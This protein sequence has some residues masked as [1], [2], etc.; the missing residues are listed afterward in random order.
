MLSHKKNTSSRRRSS[1]RRKSSCLALKVNDLRAI[2]MSASQ[3]SIPASD[4]VD[5]NGTLKTTQ[6][7]CKEGAKIEK[8]TGPLL[9]ILNFLV[10][11]L[12]RAKV[13]SMKTF[14]FG[15]LMI[16]VLARIPKFLENSRVFLFQNTT[17]YRRTDNL[18]DYGLSDDLQEGIYNVKERILDLLR[19]SS[20]FLFGKVI[21]DFKQYESLG[22]YD[23][24]LRA[25]VLFS[26]LYVIS[27]LGV[28]FIE[29]QQNVEKKFDGQNASSLIEPRILNVLQQQQD[30]TFEGLIKT[31]SAIQPKTPAVCFF[32]LDGTPRLT[33]LTPLPN[34]EEITGAFCHYFPGG[35]N[36][37]SL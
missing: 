36:K 15:A 13:I 27:K 18:D 20:D 4:F 35:K 12:K 11:Q 3:Y 30:V 31:I 22:F 19:S 2:L 37:A 32:R 9:A 26:V 8:K 25:V 10:T 7:F 24:T 6:A 14:Q 21:R 23:F 33:K 1:S 28:S 29:K 5:K 17:N 16:A 34:L